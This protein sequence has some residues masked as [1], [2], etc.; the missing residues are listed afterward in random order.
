MD[1]WLIVLITIVSGVVLFSICFSIKLRKN[2]RRAAA[3]NAAYSATIV[4]Q[5]T[6]TSNAQDPYQPYL[7]QNQS[8]P[9]PQQ[10]QSM[11]YPQQSQQLPY[12]PQMPYNTQ[13]NQFQQQ[14]NFPTHTQAM[15]FVPSTNNQPLFNPQNPQQYFSPPQ[16][17]IVST[18]PYNPS[19]SAPPV[20]RY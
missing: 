19:P 14:A 4:V 8:I 3:R 17:I 6:Q 9:Y 10:N 1:A 11:P 5:P 15:S 20:S 7:P 12:P 18:A 16:G 13:S 2:K